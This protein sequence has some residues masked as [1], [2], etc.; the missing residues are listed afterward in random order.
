MSKIHVLGPLLIS[1]LQQT[2]DKASYQRLQCIWLKQ[3]FAM[4][5]TQI[6]HALGWSRS[7]VKNVR[8]RY[9]NGGVSALLSKP[10][11]G[12]R[13]RYLTFDQELRILR[14]F[15]IG[16]QRGHPFNIQGLHRATEVA[17]RRSVSKSTIYRMVKRHSLKHLLRSPGKLK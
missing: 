14:P 16:A 7:Q 10:R 1:D 9:N 3:E 4:E 12:P 8:S 2:K 5:D 13:H 15:V 17:A 11:G 6:A